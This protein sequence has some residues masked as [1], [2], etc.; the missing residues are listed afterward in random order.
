MAVIQ[1]IQICI[2][3]GTKSARQ[4]LDKMSSVLQARHTYRLSRGQFLKKWR[5]LRKALFLTRDYQDLRIRVFARTHGKCADCQEKSCVHLHHVIPVA[6][7][8]HKA[9]D[10]ANCKG[11]CRDCHEEAHEDGTA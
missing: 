3:V 9:L 2:P 11:L 4:I 7:A 5:G 8:P 6:Y 10:D 1:G